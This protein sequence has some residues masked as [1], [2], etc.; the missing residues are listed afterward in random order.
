[1]S[2]TSYSSGTTA[3]LS[4]HSA[5]SLTITKRLGI[6]DRTGEPYTVFNIKCGNNGCDILTLRWEYFSDVDLGIITFKTAKDASRFPR[7]WVITDVGDTKQDL[8]K[9]YEERVSK[10]D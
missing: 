8:L 10:N 3:N 9:I 7:R 2:T 4:I 1:M 5:T 6:N